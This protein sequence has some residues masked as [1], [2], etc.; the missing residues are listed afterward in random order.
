[1][2]EAEVIN[3]VKVTVEDFAVSDVKVIGSQPNGGS[4]LDY[5]AVIGVIVKHE[6]KGEGIRKALLKL[7]A[8]EPDFSF[9]GSKLD[10]DDFKTEIFQV[11]ALIGAI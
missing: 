5:F 4:R 7:S 6:K 2:T 9:E 3:I 11:N 8:G 10:F 1:M